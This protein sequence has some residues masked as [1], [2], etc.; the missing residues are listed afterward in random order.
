MKKDTQISL[1]VRSKELEKITELGFKY[2]DCWQ[3]G[4]ERILENERSE[5]EKL[6]QKYYN[7][8]IHVNTKLENFGKKLDNEYAELDRILKW[9]NK[10]NRSITKPTDADIQALK[11]QLSKREIHSFT[12]EQVLEYWN[13][14]GK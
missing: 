1:R 5:L 6:S 13:K 7:L 14:G 11:L 12:V 2:S 10:Q 9:Y 4:Y 8:Y 3:L